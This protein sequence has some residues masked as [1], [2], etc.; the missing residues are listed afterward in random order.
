MATR[1]ISLNFTIQASDAEMQDEA[2]VRE[3]CMQ[4]MHEVLGTN[5]NPPYATKAFED[6]VTI[7]HFDDFDDA[8]EQARDFLINKEFG[9]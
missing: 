6:T 5:W 2:K 3:L 8:D 9:L 7:E 1:A 4:K